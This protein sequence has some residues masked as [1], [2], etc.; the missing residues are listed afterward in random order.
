MRWHWVMLG[1]PEVK[2]YDGSLLEWATDPSLPME[3]DP[4]RTSAHQAVIAIENRRLIDEL[5]EALAQQAATTEVLQVINSS[6]RPR[7]GVRRDFG[8]GTQALRRPDWELEY[9]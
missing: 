3:V 9:I 1:H 5:R 4:V 6:P 7:A 2:L 8:K